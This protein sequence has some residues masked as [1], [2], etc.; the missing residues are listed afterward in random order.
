MAKVFDR[1]KGFRGSLTDE[2]V[3]RYLVPRRVVMTQGNVRDASLLMNEK[4]NVPTLAPD[5]SPDEFAVVRS[6]LQNTSECACVMKN[7]P[8]TPHAAILLDFGVEISGSARIMSWK[9]RRGEEKSA[10]VIIR[11]GESVM[12][13]LTPV[14]VKGACNDHALRDV[15]TE[16]PSLGSVE[17]GE[18]GYRFVYIELLGDDSELE[19]KAVQGVFTFLDLDYVGSFECDSERLNRIWNT[20]AYTAHLNM[21]EYLLDGIKR[22]RLVWMGD[23]YTHVNSVMA[24]FGNHDIIARSLDLMRDRTPAGEW[25]N[26]I[27]SYSLW[28]IMTHHELYRHFGNRAYLGEQRTYMRSLLERL[29]TY[30]GEDG[31]EKLDGWR[32]LDW[33]SAEDTEA[34]HAGLQSL[35][36]MALEDGAELMSVLEEDDVSAKCRVSAEKLKLHKPTYSNSKSAAALLAIAGL[37]DKE[38][39]SRMI[40]LDGARR[41]SSFMSYHIL[42][43]LA[44]SDD[45]DKAMD[46]ISAYYG[47]MLDLG[48]TTFWEDFDVDWAKS[49]GRIDEI[50]PNGKDDVH[51]DFGKHCYTG[52]R[53]S[54]CH[55]WSSAACPFMSRYI[56][57]IEVLS[58]KVVRISPNL[59]KLRYAQGTYPTPYGELKVAHMRRED[60]T[61]STQIIAP[62]QLKIL[63]APLDSPDGKVSG[64]TV[65]Y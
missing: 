41:F 54:L 13:A 39:A 63:R 18:S 37:A 47:G 65:G 55:A 38:E 35:M 34:I 12:E 31:E 45:I 52:F 50:V 49:A 25:M 14:G 61:V 30:I 24:V 64:K 3:R 26:G 56:L 8:D 48:A 15:E 19:L 62:S 28:W 60:G 27:S 46:I 23:M 21:Q 51:G 16:L 6:A 57:G 5:P 29:M 4:S 17:T 32:F 42:R 43:L 20:A 33:S 10:R 7:S 36:I 2:R 9:A 53:H 44:E 40:S 59:G 22:D 1:I 11:F 58:P